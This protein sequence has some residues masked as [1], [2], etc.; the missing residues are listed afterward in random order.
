MGKING[1]DGG[2]ERPDLDQDL[3]HFRVRAFQHLGALLA[4][5]NGLLQGVF[6]VHLAYALLVLMLVN[7][8]VRHHRVDLV[9]GAR[10][11][12]GDLDRVARP[13]L[14]VLGTLQE[15]EGR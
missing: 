7:Q 12:V 8:G 9:R 15:L 5:D 11:A 6:G 13:S 2:G 10:A 1:K 14:L 3:G 4:V